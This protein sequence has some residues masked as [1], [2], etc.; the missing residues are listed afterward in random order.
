MEPNDR[1]VAVLDRYT[2]AFKWGEKKVFY[3]AQLG[4]SA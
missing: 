3:A 2:V 1:G 4:L